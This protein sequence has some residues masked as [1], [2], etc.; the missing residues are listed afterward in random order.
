M[1]SHLAKTIQ[2]LF[3]KLVEHPKTSQGPPDSAQC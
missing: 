2:T 1:K 3:P